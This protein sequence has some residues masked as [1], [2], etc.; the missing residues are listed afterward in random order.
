MA[1]AAAPALAFRG[2]G[3]S[4]GQRVV[5]ADVSFDV[6]RGEALGLVGVNGAGKT[7]LLRALLDLAPPDAGS[8]ALFGRSAAD[9]DARRQL[10]YLAERFMAPGFTTGLELLRYLLALHDLDLDLAVAE[11]QARALDFDVAALAR[12]VRHYS[13]GMAQKLGL[14][15]CV[16]ARRPLL[17]LD[18]PM[19][20]LDPRARALVKR[21]LASQKAAGVSLFFSTHMLADVEAL[22][23]RI[24]V[25]DGGRLAYVGTQAELL[26]AQG[27]S[28]LEEAFLSLIGVDA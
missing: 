8:I 7:T 4:F 10:S 9:P 16:L 11:S 22:C 15:A 21:C 5:L 23:D 20:G 2:V 3:K 12:P 19:S 6:A 14:M 27:A 25:L 26:R 18:E 13:K 24:A 17:V 1:D 28:T